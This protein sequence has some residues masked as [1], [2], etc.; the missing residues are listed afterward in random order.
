MTPRRVK[1]VACLL[2]VLVLG[3]AMPRA[4]AAENRVLGA[5]AKAGGVRAVGEGSR[6]VVKTAPANSFT[7]RPD[8][9]GAS[10]STSRN[11]IGVSIPQREARPAQRGEPQAFRPVTQVPPAGGHA[12]GE[13]VI[14]SPANPGISGPPV[15]RPIPSPH[16]PI[17][18]TSR[19]GINGTSVI[20][21]AVAP[22]G[23]GGAAKS[24]GG[25]NG[26]TFRPKH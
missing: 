17:T 12:I 22:S 13:V 15:P 1:I 9:P 4:G 21:P 10:R 23:L 16:A 8:A 14:R 25:I 19:G 7:L 2:T 18:A 20:R 3:A 24:A 26:T 11:A 6:P 5:G